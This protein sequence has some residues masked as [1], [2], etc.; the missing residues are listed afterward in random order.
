MQQSVN[1][2]FCLTGVAAQC[3]PDY[4]YVAG[5]C[6]LFHPYDDDTFTEALVTCQF[7]GGSLAKIDNCSL[8]LEVAQYIIEN[9]MCNNFRIYYNEN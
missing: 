6:F 4:A 1:F 5:R 7:L 9:G 8:M 3:P 2:L